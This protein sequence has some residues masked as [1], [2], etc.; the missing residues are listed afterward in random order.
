[1][2]SD[3]KYRQQGYRGGP[4]GPS[5]RPEP[6]RRPDPTEPRRVEMLKSRSVS[7]CAECGAVLPITAESLIQCPHCRKDLHACQQCTHFDTAQRFECAR[8][9][10]LR[11]ADKR[12]R[13]EC[14]EFSIRVTVERDTTSPGSVRPDD[15]RRAFGSL[16][17]K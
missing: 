16:F 13:N 8:P 6:A 12:A 9:V 11:V 1:M 4:S 10:A 7:R 17:E 5:A 14:Q 15:A 2:M 3:R